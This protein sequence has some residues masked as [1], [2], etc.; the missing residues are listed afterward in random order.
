MPTCANVIGSAVLVL[1]LSGLGPIW[2]APAGAHSWYPKDCC[3]DRDCVPADAIGT[4]HR[5][6]LVVSVGELRIWVPQGF[7][8]RPSQD[9][10][11]HICFHVDEFKFLMPLCLFLPAQS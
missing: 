11:V 8:S 9:S 7:A 5:G 6:D 3:S 2:H 4:D 10:R 1:C